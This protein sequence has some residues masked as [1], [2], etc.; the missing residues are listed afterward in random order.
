MEKK[1]SL[2]FRRSGGILSPS[3]L[4]SSFLLLVQSFF[5]HATV[6]WNPTLSNDC[7]KSWPAVL[8]FFVSKAC[9]HQRHVG[10]RKNPIFSFEFFCLVFSRF[11]FL[12]C[13]NDEKVGLWAN[14]F[15]LVA[16]R[17]RWRSCGVGGVPGSNDLWRWP[18]ATDLSAQWSQNWVE[19]DTRS[20]CTNV[21]TQDPL[22]ISTKREREREK[23]R[24]KRK[25]REKPTKK[26]F[27]LNRARRSGQMKSK[28]K[29]KDRD[30]LLDK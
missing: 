7:Q 1:I 19:K 27:K 17:I 14:T 3:K 30:R 4:L 13:G 29:Q 16:M 18:N 25:K 2:H 15:K 9:H 26:K 23:E 24:K 20:K 21:L 11:H 10:C 22:A 28:D 12:M 6:R 5:D 8:A